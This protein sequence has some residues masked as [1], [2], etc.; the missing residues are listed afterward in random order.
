MMGTA[1]TMC[2]VLEAAGLSLPGNA[3]LP[4]TE[5]GS[6]RVN[7]A[8]LDLARDAGRHAVENLERG[9]NFC[10]IVTPSALRNLIRVVQAIGGSTNLVLHLAALATELGYELRLEEWDELGRQTP[11]LARF[12]PA[13]P[14]TVSDFGRTSGVPALLKRLA[15]LLDLDIPTAFGGTLADVAARAEITDPNIIR[16]LDAPWPPRAG[17]Q[18]SG[19]TWPRMGPSSKS[20]GSLRP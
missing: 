4:A 13:S 9:I 5:P 10:H 8:L 12:K 1:N 6:R 3:T 14:Q 2:V 17:S 18:S 15:P 11:L 7:P 20:A 16:P 19:A